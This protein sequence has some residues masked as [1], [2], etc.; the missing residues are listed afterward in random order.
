MPV[1]LRYLVVVLLS[2]Y[3]GIHMLQPSLAKP[4]EEADNNAKY[5]SGITQISALPENFRPPKT[6]NHGERRLIFI[7]DVHGAYDELVVHFL[8]NVKYK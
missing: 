1:N 7:G 6:H 8:E 3:G 2:L 5:V 4:F